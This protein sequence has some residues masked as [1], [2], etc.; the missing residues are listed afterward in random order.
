MQRGANVFQR[1]FLIGEIKQEETQQ[2][3]L[4]HLDVTNLNLG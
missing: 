4:L 3:S 1:I 2:V